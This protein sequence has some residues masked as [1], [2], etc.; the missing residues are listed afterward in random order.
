MKTTTVSPFSH[1]I[2]YSYYNVNT[3]YRNVK[4]VT[5]SEPF[6]QE[7]K[8]TIIRE[9][10]VLRQQKRPADYTPQ[11]RSA[12][13]IVSYD[14]EK[15]LR[16]YY[17]SDP[18]RIIGYEV[19]VQGNYYPKF[20]ECDM[21]IFT[22]DSIIIGEIKSKN[23]NSCAEAVSQLQLRKEIVQSAYPEK[24]VIIVAIIVDMSSKLPASKS[25]Y[26]MKLESTS[27][28]FK[29][30]HVALSYCDIK[31]LALSSNLQLDM[32]LFEQAHCEAY[33]SAEHRK[34]KHAKRDAIR[35][36]RKALEQH[37]TTLFGHLLQQALQM[38]LA[39]I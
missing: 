22:E 21:V 32:A 12:I 17:T 29:F 28:G 14:T 37:Q 6:Y 24:Q 34:A 5:P 2:G 27:D 36:E 1:A 8:N 4:F 25:H 20:L 19:K 23:N 15:L 10:L 9:N 16:Y 26:D 33:E 31:E 39:N 7:F 30:Y 38:E 13:S 35:N 18:R 3:K 11:T